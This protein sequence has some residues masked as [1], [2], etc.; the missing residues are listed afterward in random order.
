MFL[1]IFTSNLTIN[2]TFVHTD[3]SAGLQPGVN[4]FVY[5]SRWAL[6]GNKPTPGSII[7][8]NQSLIRYKASEDPAVKN[9]CFRRTISDI[10]L[11]RAFG[12]C[13]NLSGLRAGGKLQVA[14]QS[15]NWIVVKRRAQKTHGEQ[16]RKKKPAPA[17]NL[18]II[19]TFVANVVSF[20]KSFVSTES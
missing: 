15:E 6:N 16:R 20:S 3:P 1:D 9:D 10:H 2:V 19:K 14:A 17:I 7:K 12:N 13:E 4:V 8:S 11:T 18:I 5:Y